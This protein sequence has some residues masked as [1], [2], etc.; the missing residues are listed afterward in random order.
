MVPF[1]LIVN[2]LKKKEGNNEAA[3]C[4]K[5]IYLEKSW[6]YRFAVNNGN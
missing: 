3:K 5:V 1:S 4:E 2:V 6:N